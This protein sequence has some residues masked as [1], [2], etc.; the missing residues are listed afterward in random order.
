MIYKAIVVG[1]LDSI[2]SSIGPIYRWTTSLGLW[3]KLGKLA[4]IGVRMRMKFRI[5]V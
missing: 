5:L 3:R 2:V 1:G 4:V